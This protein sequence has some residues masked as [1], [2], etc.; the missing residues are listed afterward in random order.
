M[1]NKVIMVGHLTKDIEMRFTQ[2]G[3]AIANTEQK[4]KEQTPEYNPFDD[5]FEEPP[6]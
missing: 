1:Y 6:F 2:G 4:S 5:E 3:L